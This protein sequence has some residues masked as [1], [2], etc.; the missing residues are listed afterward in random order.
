MAYAEAAAPRNKLQMKNA[1]AEMKREGWAK[2]FS[3]ND[4]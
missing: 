2:G 1:N 4:E 3:L